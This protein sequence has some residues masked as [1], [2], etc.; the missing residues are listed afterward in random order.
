MSYTTYNLQFIYDNIA[1]QWTKQKNTLF[2]GLN[3]Q[4]KLFCI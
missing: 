1:N 4:K 2:Y 3:V